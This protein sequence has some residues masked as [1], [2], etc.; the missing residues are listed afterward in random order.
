MMIIPGG[1]DDGYVGDDC[2][3]QGMSFNLFF[4][5]F[6]SSRC[7]D[8][9]GDDVPADDNH[10]DTTF[11]SFFC[12]SDWLT[13]WMI[14]KYESEKCLVWST[15][16]HHHHYHHQIYSIMMN[17]MMCKKTSNDDQ[18]YSS[19]DL[20]LIR[21]SDFSFRFSNCLFLM[22]VASI[23][24]SNGFHFVIRLSIFSHRFICIS[25]FVLQRV[26]KKH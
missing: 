9:D 2:K 8:V 14:W 19:F 20:I 24:I 25:S 15:F 4:F 26:K 6:H 3:I 21:S 23:W 10:I 12:L 16:H 1:G 13:D 5:C 18:W 7:I 11:S 22:Y 17:Q